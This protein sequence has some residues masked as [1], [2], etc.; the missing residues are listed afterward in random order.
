[1]E[2][3]GL[4][5]FATSQ[6]GRRRLPGFLA[7]LLLLLSSWSCIK[8][9]TLPIHKG[10]LDLSLWDPRLRPVLELAGEWEFAFNTVLL[11]NQKTDDPAFIRWPKTW[12]S[13][14]QGYASYRLRLKLP[15]ALHN[16]TLALFIP[17]Q[18]TAMRVLLNG[19][20]IFESGSFGT[21]ANTSIPSRDQTIVN[22]QA[23]EDIEILVHISNYHHSR[24]GTWY[25]M[26]F[27][28]FRDVV[29]DRFRRLIMDSLVI[30]MLLGLGLYFVFSYIVNRKPLSL[31]IGFTGLTNALRFSMTSS[32]LFEELIPLGFS[33]GFRLEYWSL[34]LLVQAYVLFAYL[35]LRTIF[36]RRIGLFLLIC[37]LL[38]NAKVFLSVEFFSR[39]LYLAHIL[40]LI[41]ILYCFY[42]SV[43]GLRKNIWG[44]VFIFY[45]SLTIFTASLIDIILVNVLG[46]FDFYVI[47]YG[48]LA[49]LYMQAMA[50]GSRELI[51]LQKIQEE[52]E[53]RNHSYAQLG[54]IV[55]PH[56]MKMI[57]GG[58]ILE[59]TMPTSD[60]EAV[61][62]SFD[63]IGSSRIQHEKVKKFL[64]DTFSR[65]TQVMMEG[66]DSEKLQAPAYRI[67]EVG[68]GFLCSVGYPFRT[69]SGSKANDALRLA[70]RFHEILKEEARVLQSEAPTCCGIGLALDSI[71]GFYPESGA[72]EYDVFG[73][74]VILA[75]RY[76]AMRKYI[77][78]EN[79]ESSIIILQSRVYDSLDRELRDG[80]N[81]F[82]LVQHKTTVRDD[83]G[84]TV[85]YYKLM[86]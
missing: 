44:S 48:S 24:G 57:Q 86:A 65:C 70:Y 41:A 76:E 20:K 7:I 60:S 40:C 66:Y 71:S 51:Y 85:L 47:Q 18:S 45:G 84:A 58:K 4:F 67:K 63:I 11:P 22:F 78:D 5:S 49:F 19:E 75:T 37:S 27:G 39:Y 64:R 61:V 83:S 29:D 43:K 14:N 52:E 55:Y 31:A 17:F 54:K 23:V 3:S 25:T 9:N 68:D 35:Y 8:R 10:Q 46:N 56:Q 79:R 36:S 81:R 16:Q 72:K 6:F 42:I 12:T 50:A 32:R 53:M 59:E 1:M 30:F 69:I 34:Y 38:V 21:D 33:A 82:D 26:K 77:L 62:I 15:R 28:L 2:V 74:S 13:A 80:F 73:R